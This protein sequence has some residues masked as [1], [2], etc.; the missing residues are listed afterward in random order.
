MRVCLRVLT[1]VLAAAGLTACAVLARTFITKP[2]VELKSV[3]V[4][5]TTDTGLTLLLGVEI[6]NPNSF[7]LKVDRLRYEVELGGRSFTTGTLENAA[8]VPGKSKAEVKIPV[9]VKFAD[10]LATALDLWTKRT[11]SYR[12]KGGATV[13]FFEL[14]FDESGEIKLP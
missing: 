5:E 3:V 8:E 6:D 10:M 12:V 4:A 11:S 1:L 14:P 9:K 2:K 13:G 7:A